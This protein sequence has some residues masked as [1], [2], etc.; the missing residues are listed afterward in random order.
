ML[1]APHRCGNPIGRH[2]LSEEHDLRLQYS[3]AMRAGRHME[4]R[5]VGCVEV[6]V[7]VGR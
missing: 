5:V 4:L 7:A 3:T 1:E 2:A 6:R